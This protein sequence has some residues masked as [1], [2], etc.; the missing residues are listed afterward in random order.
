MNIQPNKSGKPDAIARL[1]QLLGLTDHNEALCRAYLTGEPTD[2]SLL[3]GAER[4]VFPAFGW[5]K[6]QEIF[7]VLQ[8]VTAPEHTKN[9]SKVLKLLWAIGRSTAGF[10][11]QFDPQYV[12]HYGRP[13]SDS[14]FRQRCEVLGPAAA[15]AIDA[16][17]PAAWPNGYY[18]TQG[19]H[20]L[21][22]E[23]PNVLLEAQK[24]IADPHRSLADGVLAGIL[25]A[26]ETPTSEKPG[27]L[28]KLLGRTSGQKRVQAGTQLEHQ[29]ELVLAWV[30]AIIAGAVGTKLSAG[31]ISQLKAYIRAGDP[32]SPVPTVSVPTTW[33]RGADIFGRTSDGVKTVKCI[34]A[35][36]LFGIPH[37]DRLAC[38]MRVLAGLDLTGTLWG[39][40]CFLPTEW[41]VSALDVLIP[42]IPGGAATLLRFVARCS[43]LHH[44]EFGK[45]LV[46]HFCAGADEALRYVSPEEY[47]YLC[48]VLPAQNGKDSARL[49][50]M[51]NRLA[52]A[53]EKA[54]NQGPQRAIVHDYLAGQGAFA[55][56][57]AKLKPIPNEYRYHYNYDMHTIRG[58][59]K[60]SG[61]DEFACRCVVLSCL[62]CGGYSVSSF[63]PLDTT[64]AFVDALTTRGLPV[65]DC[66][67]VLATM[68]ELCI[69]RMTKNH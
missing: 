13:V 6:P 36:V 40:I 39:A 60:L 56:S 22:C 45:K 35:S 43:D 53:L 7:A 67:T 1:S 29:V 66:M 9:Q 61:W 68:Y 5:P 55:D 25:L 63:F 21:A 42:H 34:A 32:K 62:T 24:L 47:A 11:A 44:D 28:S 57:A 59:Q 51:R 50:G 14:T 37:D 30:D 65:R 41:E 52:A 4:Q 46:H 27:F 49:E 26:A 8:E 31:D 64:D 23:N 20:Q 12:G 3:S 58:Y 33:Q 17:C 69:R 10:A 2:D 54:F 48:S 38:A 15:A 19:L 18:Q 16:E